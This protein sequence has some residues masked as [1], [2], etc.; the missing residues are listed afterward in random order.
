MLPV[1]EEEQ[2]YSEEIE[3]EETPGLTWK[4]DEKRKQIRAKIDG[5]EAIRQAIYCMLRTERFEHE[6]YSED[7]GSEL[8]DLFG[9]PIAFVE[10]EVENTITETL[11]QDDRIEAVTDFSF[12]E[13]PYGLEVSFTAETV[14]GRLNMEWE[15]T[16]Q[17]RTNL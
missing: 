15:V 4:L 6:I 2:L 7:Y 14:E 17:G 10:M 9:Q 13:I 16:Q 3:E 5:L 8:T 12:S 11:I 1:Y